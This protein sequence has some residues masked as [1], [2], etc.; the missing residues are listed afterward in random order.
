MKSKKMK[1][2]KRTK[3]MIKKMSKY[4]KRKKKMVVI[5]RFPYSLIIEPLKATSKGDN[6]SN[7][8]ARNETAPKKGKEKFAK[9]PQLQE[10]QERPAKSGTKQGEKSST[11]WNTF[12]TLALLLMLVL[13]LYS[14][15]NQEKYQKMARYNRGETMDEVI[16]TID[17]MHKWNRIYMSS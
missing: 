5:G 1:I 2:K 13:L 3:K 6:D 8:K 17:F 7:Q 10:R 11:L 15:Y 9:A 14:K 16:I 12:I 4:K